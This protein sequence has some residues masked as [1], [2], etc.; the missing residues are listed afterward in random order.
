MKSAVI[1]SG[2][3]GKMPTAAAE[4]MLATEKL[5]DYLVSP[6][7]FTGPEITDKTVTIGGA[8]IGLFKRDKWTSVVEDERT[9]G[10]DVYAIDF[11]R[12]A[13]LD[14]RAESIRSNVEFYCTH[15]I[16]FVLGAI[17]GDLQEITDLV[18]RSE[19]CAVVAPNMCLQVVVLQAMLK[20]GAETFPNA[21][22]GFSLKVKESHQE[23]K[24]QETSGTAKAMVGY[25]KILGTIL[26]GCIEMV[27][28]PFEQYKMGVAKKYLE[29]HGWHSYILALSDIMFFRIVHN[30]NGREPYAE[31]AKQA[32]LFLREQMKR[33]K[34]GEV[35]SMI[36][37]AKGSANTELAEMQ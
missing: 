25:F 11:S 12:S 8:K 20:Y 3:P 18:K 5:Y 27:R 9:I 29:G 14:K 6:Q 7:A 34:K 23:S 15:K 36:D 19:I 21:F 37:V 24:G 31:G 33:G 17:G 4:T 10:W 28:D 1:I 30:I 32:F 13:D 22:K 35:F 26:E 2:L 16:P